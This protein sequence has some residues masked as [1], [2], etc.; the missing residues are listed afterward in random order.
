[1]IIVDVRLLLAF[2]MSLA[3]SLPESL[4]GWTVVCLDGLRMGFGWSVR[5]PVDMVFHWVWL[6]RR[7]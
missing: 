3:R 7:A 2:A 6:L 4:V 5:E 1:M